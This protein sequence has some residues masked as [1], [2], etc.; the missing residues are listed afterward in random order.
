MALWGL[1]PDKETEYHKD[2]SY[3][4]RYPEYGVSVTKDSDGSVRE[5]TREEHVFLH[6]PVTTTYDGDGRRINMQDRDD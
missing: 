4:E 3:T 1:I 5:E 2:G 6:G